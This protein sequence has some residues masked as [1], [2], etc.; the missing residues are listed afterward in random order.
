MYLTDIAYIFS[1][2][3]KIIEE[4]GGC[5]IILFFNCH[6]NYH[7][8]FTRCLSFLYLILHLFYRM[9]DVSLSNPFYYI[10]Q[11][12]TFP[13]QR[14]FVFN[15]IFYPTFWRVDFISLSFSPIFYS[16]YPGAL[17]FS[18]CFFILVSKAVASLTHIPPFHFIFT[19]HFTMHRLYNLTYPHPLA[20]F[21]QS[22]RFYTTFFFILAS[23]AH[24]LH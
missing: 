6:F 16:L 8:T 21:P 5:K 17:Y 20:T 1:N 7:T 22:S 23:L 18:P 24:H 15:L 11:S 13:F 10:N 14:L 19:I 12:L 4:G 2:W 3:L 9:Q